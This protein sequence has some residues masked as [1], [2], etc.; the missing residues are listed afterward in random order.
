MVDTTI[1]YN[2]NTVSIQETKVYNDKNYEI[3]SVR[4]AAEIFSSVSKDN[5]DKELKK[6]KFSSYND[7]KEKSG[8]YAFSFLRFIYLLFF[9]FFLI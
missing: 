6:N 2:P 7:D 8:L 1:N 5:I 3:L 9:F 4:K